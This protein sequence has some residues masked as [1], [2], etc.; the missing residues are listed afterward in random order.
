MNLSLS[1]F[2]L[3]TYY[4][5]FKKKIVLIYLQMC[6]L[7]LGKKSI[8]VCVLRFDVLDFVCF[9]LFYLTVELFGSVCFLSLTL[10]LRL[11]ALLFWFA[12]DSLHCF[13][14]VFYVYV[15]YF[16][17]EHCVSVIFQLRKVTSANYAFQPANCDAQLYRILP[18]HLLLQ[19]L[20]CGAFFCFCFSSL[21]FSL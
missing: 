21:F 16:P 2:G 12:F 10:E 20:N 18:W 7:V 9:S 1:L 4:C 3:N 17:M 8:C 13:L 5:G 11:I 14:V 19:D 15:V 6:L